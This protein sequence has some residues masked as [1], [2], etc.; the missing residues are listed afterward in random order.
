LPA[1]KPVDA[2][3]PATI[4]IKSDDLLYYK[5]PPI[6]VFLIP[7]PQG[8]LC[9]NKFSFM[10]KLYSLLAL[11]QILSLSVFAQLDIT[12]NGTG[13]TSAGIGTTSDGYSMLIQPADQYIVIAGDYYLGSTHSVGLVRFTKDGVLDPAFGFGGRMILTFPYENGPVSLGIQSNGSLIVGFQIL[14][15]NEQQFPIIVRLTKTG[16]IDYTF[17]S[18]G[19]IAP[20]LPSINALLIQSD[21]KI[22]LGSAGYIVSRCTKDGV[23][24]PGF[25]TNGVFALPGGSGV[26]RAMAFFSDG[27]IVATGNGASAG[28]TIHLSTK[29]VQDKTFGTN[30][31]SALTVNNDMLNIEGVTVTPGGY[32][33]LTGNYLPAGSSDTYRYLIAELDGGGKL[34]P[35][36]AGNG[37]L[38]IPIANYSASG[39][40]SIQLQEGQIMMAGTI[41]PVSGG[42]D[43][44]ALCRITANGAIDPTFG[45]DGTE[46]VGWTNKTTGVEAYNIAFQG[47][48]IVVG[49]ALNGAGYMAMRFL[50]PIILPPPPIVDATT[51][52]VQNSTLSPTDLP[53]RLYPNPATQTLNV[54]GLDPSATTLLQVVDAAG[55]SML[56]TRLTN[57][58]T[59][60]LDISQLPAG[61]YFLTLS[62]QSGKKTLSFVKTR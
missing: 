27:S 52:T 5:N 48:K 20:S 44:V 34:N 22:V 35:G 9:I 11:A 57:Q 13:R 50:N 28:Q 1:A 8:T 59:H 43:Q 2:G 17:S 31:I 56:S 23:F 60:A 49:G 54:Q 55:H 61:T 12:F 25:G 15:T 24:D 26:I 30:G 38:G 10:K 47:N 40:G 6:A 29:G 58:T 33:L 16:Q 51:S 36:F 45:N 62:T 32:I 46:I 53:L 19:Y 21:D 4:S 42:A 18:T 3:Y 41:S 14:G 39:A 7:H 37:K